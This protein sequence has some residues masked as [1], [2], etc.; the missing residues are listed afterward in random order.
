MGRSKKEDNHWMQKAFAHN[1]GALHKSLHVAQGDKIP[2]RKLQKAVHSLNP[3][4]RKRAQAAEN[5]KHSRGL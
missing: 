2:D 5:A 3:L 1:K 4:T